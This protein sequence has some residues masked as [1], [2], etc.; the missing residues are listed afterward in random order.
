MPASGQKTLNDN[1]K[2]YLNYEINFDVENDPKLGN[3]STSIW[4]SEKSLQV[5]KQW[6]H[7][8]RYER[9]IIL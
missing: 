3:A 6:S 7:L 8:S 5:S 9:K 1:F 4:Y 2:Q